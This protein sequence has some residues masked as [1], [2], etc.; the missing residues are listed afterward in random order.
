MPV[1]PASDGIECLA[2]PSNSTAKK[3]VRRTRDEADD[4]E[5][6]PTIPMS[7]SRGEESADDEHNGEPHRL[8]PA[9]LLTPLSSGI[10][11]VTCP[12]CN[13]RVKE[14]TI[15]AHID[16]NCKDPPR[17]SIV[18]RMGK[19]K[20]SSSSAVSQWSKIMGGPG[21]VKKKKSKS[22]EIDTEA[23]V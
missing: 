12:I 22:A 15:N 10:G 9:I 14:T 3:P 1:S 18:D 2:G 13:A 7:D 5:T 6:L 16:N 19:Q 8:H 11:V 17:P 23:Y 21:S 20:L 4:N